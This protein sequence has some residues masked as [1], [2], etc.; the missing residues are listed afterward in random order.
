MKNK[1]KIW[2]ESGLGKEFK[3]IYAQVH[4]EN[5]C[6][7]L[8]LEEITQLIIKKVNTYNKQKGIDITLI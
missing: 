6:S 7:E 1:R 4:K 2:E 5:N 3:S 8:C